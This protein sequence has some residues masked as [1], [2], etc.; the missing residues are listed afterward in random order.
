MLQEKNN[1]LCKTILSDSTNQERC[2]NFVSYDFDRM[3]IDE[4]VA[5]KSTA[6]CD[7]I[8]KSN[9]KEQCQKLSF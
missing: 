9:A 2:F 3:I 5:A 1:T 8:I 6:L 7:R 4:V